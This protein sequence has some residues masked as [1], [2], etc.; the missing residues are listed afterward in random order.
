MK[1]FYWP[2]AQGKRGQRKIIVGNCAPVVSPEHIRNRGAY[3]EVEG[4]MKGFR[5][6]YGDGLG[7]AEEASQCRGRREQASRDAGD[8][9]R[10]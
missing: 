8:R 9:E 6:R 5:V 7:K 3:V 10:R 4:E 2:L 1:S